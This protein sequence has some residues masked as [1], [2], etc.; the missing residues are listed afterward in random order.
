MLAFAAIFKILFLT[1][2][3]LFCIF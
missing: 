3:G 1:V 2:L